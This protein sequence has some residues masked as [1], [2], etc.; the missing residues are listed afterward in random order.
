MASAVE[1]LGDPPCLRPGELGR[2]ERRNLIVRGNASVVWQRDARTRRQARQRLARDRIVS[3]TRVNAG[4]EYR[5]NIGIR[6]ACIC[7]DHGH[8]L[9]TL[10]E[11]IVEHF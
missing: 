11:I 2:D 5:N 3:D 8:V 1:A 9:F 4:H 7:M 6:Y 10:R